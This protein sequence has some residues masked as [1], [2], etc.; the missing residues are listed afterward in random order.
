MHRVLEHIDRNL[1]QELELRTLAKVAHFSAFH[2]HRVFFAWTGETLGA[3][4]RRRRLEIAAARLAGQPK[5]SILN[6]AVSVGFGSTEAFAR[7]FRARFGCTATQWRASVALQ[8]NP[9]QR[10]SNPS[11]AQG[12]LGHNNGNTKCNPLGIAMKVKVI[13]RKPVKVTY[14]RH[15]GAYGK[16]LSEFWQKTAY[17]WLAVNNQLGQ[18]RYGISL[19]D[20]KIT[21][22]AKCRYDAG[23]EVHGKI[24]VPGESQTTTIPGGQYA[25]TP[26]CGT[27]EQVGDV[28]EAMLRD[29]LPKSGMQLDARPFFEYYPTDASFDPKT[30]VFTCDIAIPV[31]AI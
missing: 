15:V 23:V 17:P 20:P 5:L 3:Y 22:A 18:P 8:S 2:F 10:L 24:V 14:L 4:L 11:Q 28:W 1:D 26:F 9:G 12:E 16:P 13:D 6:V 25:V 29:W 19:D 21:V 30:G 27:V 7:A 31:A